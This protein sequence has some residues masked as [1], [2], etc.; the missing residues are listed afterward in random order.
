MAN[1]PKESRDLRFYTVNF[2]VVVLLVSLAAIAS[3]PSET[4]G[5]RW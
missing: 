3:S 4:P 2:S 5:L 1:N